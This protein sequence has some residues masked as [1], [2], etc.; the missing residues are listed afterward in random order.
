M[1][2]L[3]VVLVLSSVRLKYGLYMIIALM[4]SLNVGLDL[5]SCSQMSNLIK[6]RKQEARE[7]SV[8]SFVV[9][10]MELHLNRNDPSVGGL[11]LCR[12]SSRWRNSL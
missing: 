6:L 7:Q 5:P 12:K 1:N 11:L 10:I 2:I 9:R 4:E 3:G 8:V